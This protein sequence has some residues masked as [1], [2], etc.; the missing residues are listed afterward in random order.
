MFELLDSS[1]QV[2]EGRCIDGRRTGCAASRRRQPDQGD[3]EV[4]P[5][6]GRPAHVDQGGAEHLERP[7]D[8]GRGKGLRERLGSGPVVVGELVGRHAHADEE[9]IAQ[10]RQQCLTQNPGLPSTRD[11]RGD[12]PQCCCCVRV[13]EGGKQFG[14][15]GVVGNGPTR[16]SPVEGGE[17]V[18][19]RAATGPHRMCLTLLVHVEAGVGDHV[20]NQ[21]CDLTGRQQAQLEVL[22]PATDGLDDLVG[23]GGCEHEHDVAGRFLERLEQGVLG[24]RGEHVD[25][26]EE[27][28]LRPARRA[29]GDLGKEVADVIDLVVGCGV[30]FVQVEGPA[31]VDGHA[32]LALAAGLAIGQRRAVECL[33]EDPGGGGLAGA[34]GPAQEVGVVDAVLAHGVA[35]R[36]DDVVLPPD[37]VEP[38]RSVAAVEG[39]VLHTPLTLQRPCD[40]PGGVPRATAR[41]REWDSN[42]R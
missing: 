32:R 3:L 12:R 23:F 25:L 6:I 26:V 22:G 36:R 42:P 37:L 35:E 9:G 15:R 19:C 20:G 40:T 30:E 31:G 38:A 33:G 18:A 1:N 39:R 16:H 13:G 4:H 7:R 28:H 8:R 14:G 10:C 27:V 5:R 34:P 29:E 17:R 24:P 11:A 41:R 21:R 2:V